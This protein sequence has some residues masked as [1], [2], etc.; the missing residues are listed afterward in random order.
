MVRREG[1]G[2]GGGGL[3]R[4]VWEDESGEFRC[5]GGGDNDQLFGLSPAPPALP[6]WTLVIV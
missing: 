3:T 5:A 2:E 1:E 4:L 6:R